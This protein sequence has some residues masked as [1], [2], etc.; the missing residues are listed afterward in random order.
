MNIFERSNLPK[1]SQFRIV[2]GIILI[3]AGLALF[4]DRF[5]QTGW[6]SFTI[7]PAVGFFLYFSGL[8]QHNTWLILAGGIVSGIGTGV[9]MALSPITYHPSLASQVGLFS[10]YSGIGWVA[11]VVSTRLFS[12]KALLWGIVPAGVLCG[13]G[14]YFIFTPM[15]WY[16][17]VLCLGLGTGFSLLIWGLISKLIGLVI[18]GCILVSA[19]PGIYLAWRAPETGN[20]LVHTGIMLVW[21]A[22]G[23][24]LITLSGRILI[25]RFLWWPLIPGGILA[26]V[27]WGL[28]IGG[29]PENALVFISNTGSVGLM[30]F[31]LYLLLMRKGIHH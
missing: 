20:P 13:V 7:L 18:P 30:I 14:Y 11:V 6:L 28:Y 17:L 31:G 29:D 27:G 22:L 25:H 2:A 23:W 15:A 8:K 24:A 4:V 9:A 3:L 16:D 5:L 10:I 21:L 12:H 19:A 26:M 1:I